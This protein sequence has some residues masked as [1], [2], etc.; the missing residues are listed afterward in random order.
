M[1]EHLYK[2]SDYFCKSKPFETSAG[3]IRLVEDRWVRKC[4]SRR[5]DQRVEGEER[6]VRRLQRI[7]TFL[8]KAGKPFERRDAR[9]R[10][11]RSRLW[12]SARWRRWFEGRL[13]RTGSCTSVRR[14]T[15]CG[16]AT[17]RS[18]PSG[19][20]RCWTEPVLPGGEWSFRKS[21]TSCPRPSWPSRGS[22][23]PNKFLN[24]NFTN[25]GLQLSARYF[26]LVSSLNIPK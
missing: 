19:W 26:S 9:P 21:T 15:S 16:S 12:W 10:E 14:S 17:A 22:T 24:I 2:R 8:G 4:R 20:P 5:R 23:R 11:R 7:R 18:R 6:R 25:S 13:L 1:R 3:R